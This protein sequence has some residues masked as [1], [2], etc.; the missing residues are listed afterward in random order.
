MFESVSSASGEPKYRR[1]GS[2]L[3]WR[4]CISAQLGELESAV[5]DLREA[6]SQGLAYDI[7]HHRDPLLEPLRDDPAFK[8]LM[9]AL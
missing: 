8:E 1:R 4:A 5:S 6:F 7:S 2:Y 9:R 3:F